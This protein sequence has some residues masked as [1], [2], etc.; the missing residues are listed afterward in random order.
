[1]NNMVRRPGG[2]GALGS[3]REAARRR[4]VGLVHGF[5]PVALVFGP[6]VVIDVYGLA[7]AV[8]SVVPSV[9]EIVA[10]FVTCGWLLW[11]AWRRPVRARSLLWEAIAYAVLAAA[12]FGCW[13]LPNA[14][15]GDAATE[16]VRAV[17]VLLLVGR[18]VLARGGRLRDLAPGEFASA[19]GAGGMITQPRRVGTWFACFSIMWT[20]LFASSLAQRLL[21]LAPGLDA[22]PQDGSAG[23]QTWV[24]IIPAGPVEEIAGVAAMVTGLEYARRPPWEIYTATITARILVHLH[25]GIP[26][27]LCAGILALG[28]TWAY[29]RYGNVSALATGHTLWDAWGQLASSQ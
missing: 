26:A 16:T 12:W 17:L 18:L 28:S 9:V 10:G 2:P 13:C 20:A 23:W 6:S 25:F 14:D 4:R 19:S 11:L 21:S 22:V 3:A 1:M 27:C 7:G 15:G 8:S 24:D 5:G 29:R